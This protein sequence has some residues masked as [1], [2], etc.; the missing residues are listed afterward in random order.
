M[1]GCR[2]AQ[3][4]REVPAAVT[5]LLAGLPLTVDV[6]GL[7]LNISLAGS[8]QISEEKL[9]V[10]DWGRFQS[11]SGQWQEC[12][13]KRTTALVGQPHSQP[14]C[15]NAGL[16]PAPEYPQHAPRQTTPCERPSFLNNT[17]PMLLLTLEQCIVNW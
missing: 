5:R 8:P 4:T 16:E 6:K 10:R 1:N 15:A 13:Y 2:D 12:P 7:E 11:P 14:G 3:V 17:N 9:V